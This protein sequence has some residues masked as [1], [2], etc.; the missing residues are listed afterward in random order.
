MTFRFK[1]DRGGRG[2]GVKGGGGG[3]VEGDSHLKIHFHGD[4]CKRAITVK[5]FFFS[6]R[7][8]EVLYCIRG[9]KQHKFCRDS[10]ML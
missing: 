7:D 4:W 5:G 10:F 9:N 1:L 2:G 6:Q 8:T 3:K